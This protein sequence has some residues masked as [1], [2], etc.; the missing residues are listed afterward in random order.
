M[1]RKNPEFM[2]PRADLPDVQRVW[3]LPS[4]T[5]LS[6]ALGAGLTVLGWCTVQLAGE[7]ALASAARQ[8]SAVSGLIL[9]PDAQGTLPDPQAALAG[10][11]RPFVIAVSMGGAFSILADIVERRVAAVVLDAEQPFTSLVAGVDRLL[12][13][14]TAAYDATSLVAALREREQEARRFSALTPREQHVL[15]ALLAG[16]SA[17][18]IAAADHVSLPTVRSHIRAVLTKLGV[19]S[20][21]AAVALTHRSCRELALIDRIRKLHHF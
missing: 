14:R 15:C 16:C 12:Q 21:L 11:P 9:L 20:Q 3:L 1:V 17:A 18:E 2:S 19:S 8:T 10:R 7:D 4:G 13:L 5:I 6:A